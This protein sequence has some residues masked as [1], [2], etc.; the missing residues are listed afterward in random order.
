MPNTKLMVIN[1]EIYVT[2]IRNLL[3]FR[4]EEYSN[5]LLNIPYFKSFSIHNI[6]YIASILKIKYYQR[7]QFVFKEFEESKFLYIV[8]SGEFQVSFSR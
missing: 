4:A 1:K 8:K 3:S 5:I 7:N 6:H 2:K